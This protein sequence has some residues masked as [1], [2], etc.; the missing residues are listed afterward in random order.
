MR[1]HTQPAT[2]LAVS[3]AIGRSKEALKVLVPETAFADCAELAELRDRIIAKGTTQ[4]ISAQIAKRGGPDTDYA[5]NVNAQRM[6]AENPDRQE[7]EREW[8]AMRNRRDIQI[9][10]LG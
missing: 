10:E 9:R 3:S 7:W 1:I 8:T 4:D 6:S 5:R 2:L